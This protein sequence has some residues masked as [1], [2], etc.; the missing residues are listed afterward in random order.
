MGTTDHMDIYADLDNKLAAQFATAPRL[1]YI[2]VGTDD[3]VKK[4]VDKHR[5]RLDNAGYTYTYH[6]TGGGHTWRNWRR[7]LIDLLPRLFNP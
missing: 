3:F 2:A 1:Y 6:E 4:L 7:Y 5:Q